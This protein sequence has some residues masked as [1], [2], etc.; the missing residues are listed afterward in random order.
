MNTI[1]LIMEVNYVAAS[2]AKKI[3]QILHLSFSFKIS[4]L[5]DNF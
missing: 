1:V 2:E 3:D 4:S 5:S